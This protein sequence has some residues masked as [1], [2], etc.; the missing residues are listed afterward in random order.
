[1][2]TSTLLSLTS[3]LPRL[4]RQTCLR[5]LGRETHLPQ[6]E[7]ELGL[8]VSYLPPTTTRSPPLTHSEL[9]DPVEEKVPPGPAN[10]GFVRNRHEGI[11]ARLP[12][13]CDILEEVARLRRDQNL[14]DEQVILK[15]IS[16]YDVTLATLN[17]ISGNVLCFIATYLTLS[18][19]HSHKVTCIV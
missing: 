9:N 5:V 19:N 6:G 8:W 13:D 10:P 2:L 4:T 3:T 14:S 7:S 11:L 16:T 18:T 15:L 17:Q 12:P 1:L